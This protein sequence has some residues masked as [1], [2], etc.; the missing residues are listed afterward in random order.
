MAKSYGTM[1]AA[2][3]GNAAGVGLSS[4]AVATALVVYAGLSVSLTLGFKHALRVIEFPVSLMALLLVIESVA[5]RSALCVAARCQSEES[6]G[7]SRRLVVAIGLCVAGEIGL[8][9]L[10]LMRMTVAAH[11]MI[12][13]STPLFVLCASLALGLEKPSLQVCAIVAV[14]SA[15][16]TLCSLGRLSRRDSTADV[17]ALSRV[18]GVVF[19]VAAGVAGGLR[20]GL[21]Q[22]LTQRLGAKPKLLINDTLPVAAASLL[23]VAALLEGPQL[24]RARLDAPALLAYAALLAFTGLALLWIEV[25]LVAATS[26]LSL[27]IIATAKELLLLTLSVALLHERISPLSLGGFLITTSGIIFYNLHKLE[28]HRALLRADAATKYRPLATADPPADTAPSTALPTIDECAEDED[29]DD[30]EDLPSSG[31]ALPTTTTS[32]PTTAASDDR[33]ASSVSALP[34]PSARADPPAAADG[35]ISPGSSVR[36]ARDPSALGDD[37]DEPLVRV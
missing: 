20:W 7:S 21:T 11:T 36:A 22:L 23:A 10:G 13:S 33:D 6:D 24:L 9:N 15:G 35:L 19:T 29:D 14:V 27:A 17:G 34:L 4:K 2:T 31:I 37:A 1:T 16:T 5:I 12:K 18:F 25:L 26:S 3:K 8:S 28:T 30:C 32:A